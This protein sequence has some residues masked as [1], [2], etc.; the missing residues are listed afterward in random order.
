MI[1]P[2]RPKAADLRH[3]RAGRRVHDLLD[4]LAEPIEHRA[5]VVGVDGGDAAWMA[6]VPGLEEFQ[7]RAVAHL[8]DQDAVGTKPH[9]GHDG[10]APRVHSRLH[11]HLQAVFRCTL[12]LRRVLD[13]VHPVGRLFGDDPDQGVRERGLARARPAADEDV[14]VGAHGVR[15]RAALAGREESP[16]HVI[17]EGEDDAGGL[18]EREDRRI[19]DRGNRR[20]K[21]RTPRRRQLGRER[22]A[23]G[24]ELHQ[25]LGGDQAQHPLGVRRRHGDARPDDPLA[26]PLHPDDAVGVEHHF[27]DARIVEQIGERA[28]RAL[29]RAGA[30][31]SALGHLGLRLR[32]HL[33]SSINEAKVLREIDIRLRNGALE[34][35]KSRTYL[36]RERALGADDGSKSDAER[37]RQPSTNPNSV[38]EIGGHRPELAPRREKGE[39][40][41][42]SFVERI[43]RRPGGP[44]AARNERDFAGLA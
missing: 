23:L 24:V 7:G 6:R 18:S 39:C 14:V 31:S 17:I 3:E 20:L 43:L 10:V 44:M 8:A 42:V 26:N 30:P 4:E 40:C 1:R 38:A 25:H 32:R 34:T 35:S 33:R 37:S 11:E 36:R 16:A 2:I 13:D 12:K 19:D 27:D 29:E 21:A 15:E 28:E 9:R 22:R 5:R 41:L